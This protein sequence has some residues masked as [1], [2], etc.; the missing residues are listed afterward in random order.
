MKYVANITRREGDPK[1]LQ[2]GP[3]SANSTD[4]LGQTL[5]YVG[6]G[7][8]VVE[9]VAAPR[10]TRALGIEGYE[11]LVRAFGVREIAAGVLTLSTEKEQGLWARLGGDA[12]DIAVLIAA[13]RA[14]NAR[15]ENIGLALAAVV[16]ITLLDA[17]AAEE[18][19]RRHSRDSNGRRRSYR[20][21]S[22]FP[23]GVEAARGAVSAHETE[24]IPARAAE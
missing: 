7:L 2:T 16:G 6:M 13:L 9:L 1:I 19:T 5:G 22:G 24:T 10:I 15:R 20:E 11:A 17:V 4:R 3:S 18:V 14:R 12:L 23:Q 21:R 8:G